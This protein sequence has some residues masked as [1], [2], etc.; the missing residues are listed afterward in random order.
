MPSTLYTTVR[1]L[2]TSTS[3]SVYKFCVP[4][5]LAQQYHIGDDRGC[6]VCKATTPTNN[7][8]KPYSVFH[9]PYNHEVIQYNSRAVSQS[10]VFQ[11]LCPRNQTF[12]CF[13]RVLLYRLL[14]SHYYNYNK[15]R[16]SQDRQ[17]I[18]N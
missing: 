4:T 2:Y 13:P 3:V 1:D 18:V 12:P 16:N 14:F 15:C 6:T 5:G 8:G 10:A 9:H 17:Q 11:V 7:T